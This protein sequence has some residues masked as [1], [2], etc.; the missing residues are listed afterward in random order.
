[1]RQLIVLIIVALATTATAQPCADWSGTMPLPR[2]Y[3][4]LSGREV[5]QHDDLLLAAG[6]SLLVCDATDDEVPILGRCD[7]PDEVYRLREVHGE[8]LLPA[9]PDGILR[10]D[11]SDPTEPSTVPVFHT[12]QAVRD[13]AGFDGGV[14]VTCIPNLYIVL[15]DQFETVATGELWSYARIEMVVAE[16]D[17]AVLGGWLFPPWFVD[18][19]NPANPI[20]GSIPFPDC[21]DSFDLGTSYAVSDQIIRNGAC[22]VSINAFNHSTWQGSDYLWKIDTHDPSVVRATA[23]TLDSEPAELTFH[24]GDL[25]VKKRRSLDFRSW[26]DLSTLE[27]VAILA[28][29]PGR[30]A[31]VGAHLHLGSE[32]RFT[33]QPRRTVAPEHVIAPGYDAGGGGRFGYARYEQWE[34]NLETSEHVVFFDQSDPLNPVEITH[35][36]VTWDASGNFGIWITAQNEQLAVFHDWQDFVDDAGGVIH[37]EG[38]SI[39]TAADDHESVFNGSYTRETLVDDLLWLDV[40][41]V[42]GIRRLKCFDLSEGTA[43]SWSTILSNREP[44]SSRPPPISLTSRRTTASTSTIR[45]A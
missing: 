9:G 20:D 4:H 22:V 6:D 5:M 11:L 2:Q 16:G 14:I 35:D 26:D 24:Q 19:R 38:V 12:S 36:L 3:P 37:D 31:P 1:M 33:P 44:I 30:L 8:V 28:H 17:V 43:T 27:S 7:L 39:R 23:C 13:V 25:V 40:E 29:E 18:L 32:W 42:S 34:S 41:E 15:D 45:P 10:V 21:G